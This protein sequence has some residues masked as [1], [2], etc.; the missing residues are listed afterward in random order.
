MR[1]QRWHQ[2]LKST[3]LTQKYSNQLD[4]QSL[5]IFQLKMVESTADIYKQRLMDISWFMRSLN[6]PIA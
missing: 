3:L 6:E 4:N 5:D 1:L 2:L